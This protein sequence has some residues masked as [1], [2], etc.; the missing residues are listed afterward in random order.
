M[1]EKQTG[2]DGTGLRENTWLARKSCWS[3]VTIHDLNRLFLSFK[4]YVFSA[5][6]KK[7]KFFYQS[8]N[9]L[10][11]S[12]RNPSVRDE[13]VN[14]NRPD[15]TRTVPGICAATYL[16]PAS[17]LI[18]DP[19]MYDATSHHKRRRVKTSAARFQQIYFSN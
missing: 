19:R 13:R 15:L 9:C 2:I 1:R 12:H 6:G 8:T 11:Q 17:H 4:M 14:V 3:S 16:Q 18:D 5:D 10:S 7:V